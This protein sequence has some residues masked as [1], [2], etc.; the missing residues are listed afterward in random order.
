MERNELILH[1]QPQIDCHSGKV[2]GM[3]ALIRWRHPELGVISPGRFIPIAEES[4]LIVPV[5]EWVIREACKFNKVLQETGLLHAPVA[6]NL[7]A[8]QFR[9]SNISAVIEEALLAAGLEARYLEIEVTESAFF[10]DVEHAIATMRTLK[11][12]GVSL[13]VDDFGTGYSSLAYLKRF[14]IDK[15]KVDQSF[16][17]DITTDSDDAALCSA[18]ISL[19]HKLGL[20]VIAEGVETEVQL[21]FLKEQ[22]CAIMQGFHFSRPVAADDLIAFIR[23]QCAST[24]AATI[25]A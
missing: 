23:G 4:G 16:V 10:N 22:G 6:V 24:P 25:P 19:A 21:A 7:S 13:S 12:M 15:L 1:Y 17:R 5:G 9:Q 3:E 2:V 14:P 20:T 11:D 18:I 8:I